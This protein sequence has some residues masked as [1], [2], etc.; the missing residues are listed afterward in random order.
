MSGTPPS[1]ISWFG[2]MPSIDRAIQLG[3][4]VAG[5]VVGQPLD[6]F[7]LSGTTNVGILTGQPQFTN[8]PAILRKTT[9]K[10]DIENSVFDLQVFEMT[11]DNTHLHIGDALVTEGYKSDGGVFYYVQNRPMGPSLLIRAEANASISRPATRAGAAIEQPASGA[12]AQPNYGGA[13][14][15]GE[16]ILTLSGGMFSFSLAAGLTPASVPCGLQPLNRMSDANRPA[17]PTRL[18]RERF[19]AYVPLLPGEQIVELDRLSFPNSDRYQVMLVY[20]SETVGLN[21]YICVVEKI[22]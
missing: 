8:Y 5:A 3:R 17:I 19:L 18:Y 2:T 7:R 11:S 12:I 4:G 14:R 22:D 10:K 9:T 20:T 16:Q 15:A 6:V 1:F 21:G 13:F